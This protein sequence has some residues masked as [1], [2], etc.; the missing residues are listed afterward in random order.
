MAEAWQSRTEELSAED[1]D[2]WLKQQREAVRVPAP[3]AMQAM[4]YGGTP[5]DRSYVPPPSQRGVTRTT[6]A[7]GMVTIRTSNV[8]PL[9]G[10]TP[11]APPA[12]PPAPTG[13]AGVAPSGPTPPAQPTPPTQPGVAPAATQGPSGGFGG[14]KPIGPRTGNGI[15]TSFG[16]A[17]LR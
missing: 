1:Y 2:V 12:A 8:H 4:Q 11:P 5:V 15:R 14:V 16:Q 9:R 10:T 13:F 3:G 7:N 17:E 6:D